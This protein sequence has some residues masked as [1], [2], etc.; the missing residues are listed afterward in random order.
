MSRLKVE[1]GTKTA[2]LRITIVGKLEIE[3][4]ENISIVEEVLEKI[5]EYGEARITETEII[6]N[7]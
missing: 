7:K 6:I 3:D 2:T 4:L 1:G 5:Q